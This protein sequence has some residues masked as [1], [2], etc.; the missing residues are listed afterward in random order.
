MLSKNRKSDG[1]FL[2]KHF[3]SQNATK[4]ESSQKHE[5]LGQQPIYL[6]KRFRI[7]YLPN[8]PFPS[9]PSGKGEIHPK[10]K[11]YK[12]LD[13]I[14]IPPLFYICRK[15][16]LVHSNVVSRLSWR[17]QALFIVKEE[18]RGVLKLGAEYLFPAANPLLF[19][20]A[21]RDRRRTDPVSQK[22]FWVGKGVGGGTSP[23]FPPSFIKKSLGITITCD[24][25]IL[26][27][28]KNL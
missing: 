28:K 22:F 21:E 18:G 14:Y 26:P 24:K 25:A 23:L 9:P 19:R 10:R 2:G 17:I 3:V 15:I 13:N 11:Y 5:L 6:P 27:P 16:E 1:F 8:S 7:L 4:C 20:G 12:Y